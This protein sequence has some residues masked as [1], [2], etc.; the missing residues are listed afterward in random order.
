MINTIDV[1]PVWQPLFDFRSDLGVQAVQF[2]VA[3]MNSHINQ[4]LPLATVDACVTA[5]TRP[6]A[7]TIPAD[8]QKINELLED[9]ESKTRL[10]LLNDFER[11]LDEPVEPLVHLISSWSMDSA[12]EA[13]WVRVQVLWLLRAEPELFNQSVAVSSKAVGMISRHLLTPLHPGSA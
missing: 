13:A 6:L 9:I 4:D 1:D 5:G 11:A 10:S 3:G 12:R 7:G 2:V 8:Y